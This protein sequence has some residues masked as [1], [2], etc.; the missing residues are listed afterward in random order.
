MRLKNCD[1]FSSVILNGEEKYNIE[2]YLNLMKSYHGS[3][4][5]H[6]VPINISRLVKSS[7]ILRAIFVKFNHRL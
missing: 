3:R 2:G 7:L 6:S 1:L 5:R 4:K